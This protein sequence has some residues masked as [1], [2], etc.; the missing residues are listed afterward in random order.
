VQTGVGVAVGGIVVAPVLVDP[1]AARTEPPTTKV[2]ASR[3]LAPRRQN[4]RPRFGDGSI[5]AIMSA[6][7]TPFLVRLRGDIHGLILQIDW[8]T[9]TQP[10]G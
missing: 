4:R 8:L 6:L 10:E 3:T 1:H 7:I 9:A 2:N 5:S